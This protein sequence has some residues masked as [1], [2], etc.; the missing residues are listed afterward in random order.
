MNKQISASIAAVGLAATVAL[1]NMSA[2]QTSLYST[3]LISEAEREFMA[4]IAEYGKTYGTKAEYQFRLNEFTQNLAKIEEHN[5]RNGETSTMGLNMFADYTKEEMKQLN[6]LKPETFEG[7]E[8]V[9]FDTTGLSDEV[10]WVTAGAV[11]PVKNQGQC[12]SCWSFSATGALEGAHFVASGDLVSLSEK[13]LVDCDHLQLGC[14][15]GFMG[16]AIRYSESH[17]METEAEY[18]YEPRGGRCKYD[19][20]KGVVSAKSYSKVKKHSPD[21][22]KAAIEKAPVSIAIEADKSV[23]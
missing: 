15:G 6:G 18:P 12:G 19:K 16:L 11:T 9:V 4:Y 3:G 22:L 5:S 2:E 10:N 21:Q 13:Q 20:S 17:P 23:F 14:N 7:F 1:Y 8:E